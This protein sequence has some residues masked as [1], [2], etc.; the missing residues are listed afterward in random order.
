MDRPSESRSHPSSLPLLVAA[1]PSTRGMHPSRWMPTKLIPPSL[2][3][4]S[5][6]PDATASQGNRKRRQALG[7]LSNQTFLASAEPSHQKVVIS[8]KTKAPIE[9]EAYFQRVKRMRRMES[10]SLKNAGLHLPRSKFSL[11]TKMWL[12]LLPRWSRNE[13]DSRPPLSR[14]RVHGP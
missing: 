4:S 5:Q 13:K 2:A 10:Q 9:D 1:H 6:V 7:D 14:Q 12:L 8:H 3:P 11:L